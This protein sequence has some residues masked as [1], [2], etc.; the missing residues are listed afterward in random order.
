MLAR[1]AMLRRAAALVRSS[2]AAPRRHLAEQAVAVEGSKLKFNFF[3]PHDAI[4]NN[5]EVVSACGSH[6]YRITLRSML[7]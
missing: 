7:C 4:K 5:V 1:T 6:P 2:R 3:L